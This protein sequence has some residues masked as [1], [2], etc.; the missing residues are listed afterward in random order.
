MEKLLKAA[1]A[2]AFL[3]VAACSNPE[4]RITENACTKASPRGGN[5][6]RP[7]GTCYMPLEDDLV[8]FPR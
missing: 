6:E 7:K 3:A 1:G 2:F 4:T 8:P 5:S